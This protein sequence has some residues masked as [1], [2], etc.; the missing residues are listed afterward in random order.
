MKCHQQTLSTRWYFKI[1]YICFDISV[2]TIYLLFYIN[3]EPIWLYFNRQH[4]INILK[5]QVSSKMP[6]TRNLDE[7][8]VWKAT[9]NWKNTRKWNELWSGEYAKYSYYE[10]TAN[11]KSSWCATGKSLTQVDCLIHISVVDS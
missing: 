4:F 5:L 8:Q 1:I 3:I 9:S 10:N 11:M 2:F 6:S 7:S